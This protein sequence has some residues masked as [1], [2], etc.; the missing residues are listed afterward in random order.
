M[1]RSPTSSEDEMAQSF[2]DYSVESESDSSKEETIYDTIRATAEKPSSRMEDTQNN[3]LV[4]RIIIPDLQQTKCIR[5]NPEASV[6]VAKQ[7]ILCTLNQSLKDVLNYGLFQPANNGKDGKFLDEERLLLEY[8]QPVNKGVPSLEFR[9]KK[10]VYRQMNL[11]EKHLAKLHTKANFRKCMD[12][13]HHLSVEKLTK[14]LDRGLD[15][16]YHDLETGETPLTLAAQL[17]NTVEVIKALKNGGAHLDFRAKDGMTALHKAARAK[18]QE[19]LKTLLELGA[20]PNY[21][22]SCGLTPLYHTAVV[23]GDPYCCELLLHEHATVGC[24]DE[25]GWQEIHQACRYGHVQHLEH[26]LFYGAD[27][28][29]QNASGNT[30]L[31]ICALYNQDSCA[32]VLLLRGANKELKNY[33]SQSPFQVAIIAG[34]FELAEYIKNHKETDIVPFREAPTYSNR[35]R[36]PQTTLVTP[37]VL[38]R[39]NSDNNLNINIPDWSASSL[40]SSHRS[41]SPH[42]LQQMQNNP[43]GTVKTVGSY[44]STSRSRSPS[45][46]RLGEDAKRQQHRHI[47]ASYNP[48]A[49][50]DTLSAL[51]YQ[52]PK[53]K[54]YSAVPGRLFIVVKPYQPQG[55]GEIH[56]HKGDRVKVLSIGEG[57]FWEGS[58]RGHVGWFPAECVEEVQ[59]KPNESKPGRSIL[60]VN[61][62]VLCQNEFGIHIWSLF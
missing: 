53:R 6:W 16:N 41:L 25:N 29:A 54:L 3:I 30:A 5:F 4:I 39:S 51:D 20:S 50:K 31:H 42:L 62:E 12:H 22:D 40:A 18:N 59:C 44:T 34:N 13:V 33:N 10:R 2:S 17:S 61:F 26:F 23:G 46:N 27:M 11:D 15:P 43:N 21:K 55:D 7:R 52:V 36:R 49:N 48:S 35:R 32:R 56:L 37:R 58:T 28:G 14:M 9:Y 38:L 24:K 45:L 57:G 8:P 47:S 60:K 19:T 1:P